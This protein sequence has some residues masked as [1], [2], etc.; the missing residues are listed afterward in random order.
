ML[1]DL[2]LG[3]LTF[4]NQKDDTGFLKIVKGEGKDLFLKNTFKLCEEN[5]QNPGEDEDECTAGVFNGTLTDEENWESDVSRIEVPLNFLKLVGIFEIPP[6]SYE[7]L[8]LTAQHLSFVEFFASVGIILSEDIEAELKKIKNN[9][10]IRAVS[11][12]IWNDLLNF[13]L[14]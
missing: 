14:L 12:Y 10:R 2:S 3:S 13:N 6:T 7:S 1:I 11:F 5:L 8:I 9:E 4:H